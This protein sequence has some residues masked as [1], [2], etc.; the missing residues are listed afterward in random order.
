MLSWQPLIMPEMYDR[1][2]ATDSNSKW[3]FKKYTPDV[4]VINLFQNDFWLINM[5]DHEE[6][7]HKFGDKAPEKNYIIDAYKNFV[8]TIRSKYPNATIICVLGNMD[9]IK[10]GSSW[11][12]Y[13]THAVEQLRDP[14]IYT[15]FF[16]FKNTGGHPR[17]N[18][19]KAMASSLIQFIE[20]KIKW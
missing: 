6:F 12:G 9:A 7:K 17:I 19:Q 4:V 16:E 5:P 18:E 11:P 13:I 3:D 14:K 15:H 2:D 10:M 8:K 20:R 1:L